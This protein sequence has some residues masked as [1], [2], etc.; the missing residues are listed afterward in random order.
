MAAR[1][2]TAENA[3][4]S[5]EVEHQRMKAEMAVLERIVTIAPTITDAKVLAEM[6]SLLAWAG[7]PGR[8]ERPGP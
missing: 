8:S 1:D 3:S 2:T 4:L 6:V 7:Q 5:V